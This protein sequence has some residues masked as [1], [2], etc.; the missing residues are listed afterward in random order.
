MDA[1]AVTKIVRGVVGKSAMIYNDK[2]AD[3]V[4]SI[5]VNYGHNEAQI[6]AVRA[7]L[8]A[9]GYKVSKVQHTYFEQHV[10]KDIT[11]TRLHV[12]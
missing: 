2:R 9:A 6:D 1:R 10:A 11:A 5:K 8:E 4:R 7:A 12:A 3:G